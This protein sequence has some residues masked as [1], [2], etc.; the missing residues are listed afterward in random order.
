MIII[1]QK[2]W[3]NETESEQISEKFDFIFSGQYI[4]SNHQR[5]KGEKAGMSD[6]HLLLRVEH[7]YKS[8]G[9]TKALQDDSFGLRKG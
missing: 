6:E 9:I 1:Y 3:R 5:K 2:K 8:F 4:Q 7:M